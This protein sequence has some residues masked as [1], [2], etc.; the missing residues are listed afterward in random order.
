MERDITIFDEIL[1][2]ASN[3]EISMDKCLPL[4]F[5]T[6][7]MNYAKLESKTNCLKYYPN[8]FVPNLIII[9][10]RK[11]DKTLED[12]IKEASIYY[13][14]DENYYNSKNPIK[15]LLYNT[16]HNTMLNEFDDIRTLFLR[17][18]DFFKIDRLRDFLKPKNVGYSELLCGNIVI[19]I[20]KE[21]VASSSSLSFHISIE[22]VINNKLYFYDFPCVKYGISKD[23]AY[24]FE[25]EKVEKRKTDIKDKEYQMELKMYQNT[26]D[27]LLKKSIKTKEINYQNI[28][29]MSSLLTLLN[30]RGIKEIIVPTVNINKYNGIEILYYNEIK[31]LNS[32]SE[33][34][35]IKG[36]TK[37]LE[38][39]IS[40][41]N[42]IKDKASNHPLIVVNNSINLIKNFKY[43]EEVFADYKIYDY[44]MQKDTN[45]HFYIIDD[46]GK[47]SNKLLDEL[48]QIIIKNE[49]I[50]NLLKQEK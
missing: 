34:A 48:T 39:T 17:Y 11:L 9:D 43:L 50:N 8:L 40:K 21:D 20:A 15:Y 26:I 44:P 29:V 41:I 27:N 5:Q 7:E 18:L 3:G 38:L 37:T 49:E 12:F 32:I 35:S 36:D 16:L 24:I 13:E 47:C 33:E 42:Y 23:I 31:Q 25:I 45:L 30:R 46:S 22:R 19:C 10:R 14:N 28:F 4:F 1:N 6:Y 2:E